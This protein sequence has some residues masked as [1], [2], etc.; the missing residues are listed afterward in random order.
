MGLYELEFIA[1]F[2]RTV[3]AQSED[4]AQAILDAATIA[5]VATDYEWMIDPFEFQKSIVDW[6]DDEDDDES[7]GA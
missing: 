3:E 1:T 2:R 7:E 5:D 6:P 4:E